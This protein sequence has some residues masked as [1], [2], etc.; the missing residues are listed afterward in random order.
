MSLFSYYGERPFTQPRPLT[1]QSSTGSSKHRNDPTH[2]PLEQSNSRE[3]LLIFPL[4]CYQEQWTM[5]KLKIGSHLIGSN[6]YK[7][8]QK[9]SPI[10]QV[11]PSR[12]R[13]K[14]ALVLLLCSSCISVSMQQ[15]IYD[16]FWSYLPSWP[17]YY[18]PIDYFS[19]GN[20]YDH[21]P[22]GPN[23]HLITVIIS[24]CLN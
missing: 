4:L 5:W 22:P 16:D 19:S 3:F 9:K 6:T 2:K 15:S 18:N 7:K 17:N 13:M 20:Y 11:I 23:Q 24:N 1:Q 10:V 14:L 8:G 12:Y 21:S